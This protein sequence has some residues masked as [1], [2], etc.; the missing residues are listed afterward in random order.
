[1][2]SRFNNSLSHELFLNYKNSKILQIFRMKNYRPRTRWGSHWLSMGP[3][4]PVRLFLSNS[5]QI[6][7]IA[8]LQKISAVR[9]FRTFLNEI[10][11]N[12][13]FLWWIRFE[14]LKN[15]FFEILKFLKNGVGF[16]CPII[17]SWL[18]SS[19]YH[20][21]VTFLVCVRLHFRYI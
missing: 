14:N 18:V 8:R 9:K 12:E 5:N 10:F 17:V 13:I 7:K 1:M 20:V 15:F 19:L 11:S 16:E 2:F 6:K 4:Y 21:T 3:G